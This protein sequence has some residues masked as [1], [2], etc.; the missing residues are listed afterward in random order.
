M[1]ALAAWN[2]STA[3]IAKAR[4]RGADAAEPLD[5]GPYVDLTY[6]RGAS[7]TRFSSV[8]AASLEGASASSRQIAAPSALRWCRA[9]VAWTLTGTTVSSSRKGRASPPDARCRSSW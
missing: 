6:S 5:E 3:V 9:P 4:P 8:A 1:P 7:I 2:A